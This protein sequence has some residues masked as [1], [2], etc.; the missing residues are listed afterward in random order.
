MTEHDVRQ[1]SQ[2][3]LTRTIIGAAYEVHNNLGQGFLEKVYVQALMKELRDAGLA[4]RA[5]AP[6]E[7]LYKGVPVGCYFADIMVEG[8]VICEVLAVRALLPEH[9]AQLLHYQK[10]TNTRIG[11][12]LNFGGTRVQ[13]KRMVF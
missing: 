4:A 1:T 6:I 10:A 2:L 3:E 12:L 11:L 5:E 7:V 9:D 8:T 13:V